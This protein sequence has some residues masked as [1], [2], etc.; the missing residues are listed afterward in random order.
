MSKILREICLTA[1]RPL[2]K[3]DGAVENMSRVVCALLVQ[4]LNKKIR[5]PDFWKISIDINSTNDGGCSKTFLGVF[6]VHR[7]FP[8]AEFL[9]LGLEERQ[10]YMLKFVSNTLKKSLSEKGIDTSPVDDAVEYVF[11]KKFL[12]LVVGKRKFKNPAGTEVAH[13][14]CEQEMDEARIYVVLKMGKNK[15]KIFL[16]R[17]VPEEFIFQIFFGCIEWSEPGYPVLRRPDGILIPIDTANG[18]EDSPLLSSF[19]YAS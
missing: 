12:N 5:T 2:R 17:V 14:E 16:T 13:I 10:N 7:V 11:N 6:V 18:V 19:A 8:I 3:E 4:G 9:A 15:R 1:E